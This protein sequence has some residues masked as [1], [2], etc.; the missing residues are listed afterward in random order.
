MNNQDQ[1]KREYAR[2]RSAIA[3]LARD[4]GAEPAYVRELYESHLEELQARAT[5][6]DYLSVLT[7]RA[8]RNVLRERRRSQ[9][10]SAA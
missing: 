5:V 8:V 2:H 9:Q 1:A 4:A 3:A 10:R 7:C 6:R